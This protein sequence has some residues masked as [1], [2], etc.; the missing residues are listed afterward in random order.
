MDY[1]AMM[2]RMLAAWVRRLEDS[3]LADVAEF[4]MFDGEVGEAL[5]TVVAAM[6]RN[7]HSWSEVGD[8]FGTTRQAAQQRWGRVP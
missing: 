6:R 5:E 4:V 2:R 1:A 3:D 7:G 8:T